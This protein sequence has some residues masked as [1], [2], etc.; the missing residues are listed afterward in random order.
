MDR[1]RFDDVASDFTEYLID[2][3]ELQDQSDGPDCESLEKIAGAR[4]DAS[5]HADDSSEYEIETDQ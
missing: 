1:L 4:D 5:D 3:D 2:V